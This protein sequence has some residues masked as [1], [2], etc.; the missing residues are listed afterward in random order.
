M[1]KSYDFVVVGAGIFGVTTAIVL[2][3]KE[4]SVALLNPGRIP[5]PLAASTDISKVI[6]MEYGSDTEYMAMVEECLGTWRTWNEQFKTTLYHEVGYLLLSDSTLDD[7]QTYEGA[8]YA[9]LLARGYTPERLSQPDIHRRFPAFRAEAF[10]EGFY[11]ALGGYA[12][13]GKVVTTLA[14]HAKALGVEICEETEISE[15]VV[16]QNRAIG[17]KDVKG[18]VFRGGEIVI[19]AGNAT[20]FLVRDLK[21][22]MYVTGHPVFHL[23]TSQP[24]VFEPPNLA[25]F[26]AAISKTGWYGFPLHPEHHIVKV[27]NHGPGLK[28]HALDDPR[29]VHAGDIE[30]LWQFVAERMPALAGSEIV[31]TRRCCYTDTL[32]GHFWIDRHPTIAGLTVGSGGSGHGFKMAPVIGEMIAAAA[33]GG[34]HQW[35]GR[36]RWRD[37]KSGVKN[38]EEARNLD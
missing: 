7:N 18:A 8:S 33:M 14:R 19:C 3:Q 6:R 10:K 21:S 2:A 9:N 20:P 16:E 36:Y 38:Q 1:H 28:L 30:Q 29:E 24:S 5:H 32:D 31:Y 12:E 27:A 13:S 17:V 26:G 23:R 37:L 22:A 35:S 25:V 4:Y 11:H 15:V 34:E